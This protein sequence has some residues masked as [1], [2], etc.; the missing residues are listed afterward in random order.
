M[1]VQPLT[2]IPFGAVIVG[3]VVS[4]VIILNVA[5]AVQL[6]LASLTMTV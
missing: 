5:V 2:V 3:A 1:V 4:K 6:E